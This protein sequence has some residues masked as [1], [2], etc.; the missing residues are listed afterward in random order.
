MCFLKNTLMRYSSKSHYNSNFEELV[1]CKRYLE[2]AAKP[3]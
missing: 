3:M 1:K 2:T